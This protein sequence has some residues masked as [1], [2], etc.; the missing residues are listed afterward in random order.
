[1]LV[2]DEAGAT[3]TLKFKGSEIGIIDVVD[4]DSADYEYSV[5][6]AALAEARRAERRNR[7]DDASDFAGQRTGQEGRA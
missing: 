7:P 1:M 5:D 3:L 6:G 2:S 4:K